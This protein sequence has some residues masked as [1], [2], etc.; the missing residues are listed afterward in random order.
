MEGGAL[1]FAMSLNIEA[2]SPDLDEE[3]M[4]HLVRHG[5]GGV[6]TAL[7]ERDD[8]PSDVM[9]QLAVN[10]EDEYVREMAA[11]SPSLGRLMTEDP[12]LA[13]TTLQSMMADPFYGTRMSLAERPDLPEP[14]LRVLADDTHYQVRA[15]ALINPRTPLSI[16]TELVRDAN[17]AEVAL[18]ESNW[19]LPGHLS[20]AMAM[21]DD[22]RIRLLALHCESVPL[23][24]V[25]AMAASPVDSDSAAANRWFL[26]MA[27]DFLGI[28]KAN[29]AARQYLTEESQWWTLDAES[30]EVS[31]ARTLSPNP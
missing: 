14:M 10:D 12:V 13:D 21:S 1:A 19:K 30:P 18:E 8:L 23:V 26:E 6:R 27:P 5:D 22:A 24:M 29:R 7:T 28:S 15:G 16:Q 11:S 9:V 25:K 17:V 2:A 31:L 3:R 20:G 4:W